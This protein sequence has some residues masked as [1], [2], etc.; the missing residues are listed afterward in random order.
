[1][2]RLFFV[3]GVKCYAHSTIDSTNNEA[4]RRIKNG[5]STPMLITSKSQTAGKGTRG[6]SF[7]SE[8]GGLYMSL[9]LRVDDAHLQKLTVLAAVATAKSI[10]KLSGKEVGIK[11]V[12]D[13][14]L[15]GK[16]VCGIL[17]ERVENAV[18]IGIGVNLSVKAFPDEIKNIAVNLGKINRN[19][20]AKSIV[21][22][23]L[24]ML[25]SNEDFIHYYRNKSVLIGK[26]IAYV[27]DGAE[28]KGV[29]VDIDNMGGLVVEVNGEKQT[30]TS[31]D[32]MLLK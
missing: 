31:G 3:K 29:A 20:L 10:E 24:S 28:Y 25:K 21:E 30:L 17:C 15:E 5:C 4:V 32:V 11:W 9:A 22:E 16:K 1:M 13:I 19:K 27:F 23:I 14:Y 7:Y 12:N 6:R 8:G 18:V 26:E 2:R